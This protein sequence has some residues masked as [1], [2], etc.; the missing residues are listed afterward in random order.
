MGDDLP[1]STSTAAAFMATSIPDITDPKNSIAAIAGAVPGAR[2]INSRVTVLRM[3]EA[4]NGRHVPIR[5]MRMPIIGI[6]AIEPI[7][8]TTII[9]PN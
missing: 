8:K 4:A 2:L 9:K 6:V 1:R 3:L 7:P 5:E